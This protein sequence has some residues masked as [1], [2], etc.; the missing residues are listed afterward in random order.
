V[1]QKTKCLT[2]ETIFHTAISERSISVKADLPFKLDI[3]EEEAETLE[4][5]LHNQIEIVL[6]RYFVSK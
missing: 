3:S 5:L 4:R 1:A 2:P 6:S